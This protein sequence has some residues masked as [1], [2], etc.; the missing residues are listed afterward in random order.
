[1]VVL[2]STKCKPAFALVDDDASTPAQKG[3]LISIPIPISQRLGRA[4]EK[5]ARRSPPRG[6]ER[7][8]STGKREDGHAMKSR[9]WGMVGDDV[10]NS[11]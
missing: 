9:R 8:A 10:E 1:M 3:R 11:V 2:F 4:R 6:G 7:A 5:E